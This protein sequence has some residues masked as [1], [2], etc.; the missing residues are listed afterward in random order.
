M[1]QTLASEEVGMTFRKGD[2]CSTSQLDFQNKTFVQDV[3]EST[4]L[5]DYPCFTSLPRDDE[6]PLEFRLDKT[7]AFVDLNNCFL[8]MTLQLTDDKGAGVPSTTLIAPINNIAYSMFDSIDVYIND[9]KLNEN[10]THYTWTSYLYTLLYT[11]QTEKNTILRGSGW[12]ID[13]PGQFDTIAGKDAEDKNDGFVQRMDL[14]SDG[15][16]VKTCARV[17]VTLKFDRLLPPQTEITLKFNRAPTNL[18]LIASEG[19]FRL[20]VLEAKL[21]ASRVK[22]K[23]SHFSTYTSL[24]KNPGFDY[25]AVQLGIRSKTISKGDQNFDWTPFSGPLP[26]RIYFFQLSQD[27]FNGALNLNPLNFKSFGLDKLQVFKNGLSLPGHDGF[28]N[29]VDSN[30]LESYISTLCAVRSF[31]TTSTSLTDYTYG[32]LIFCIDISDDGNASCIYDNPTH[33]GTLRIT[34][35]YKNGLSEAITIFCLAETSR[36]FAIDDDK[37]VLFFDK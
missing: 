3:I 37:N 2:A 36:N 22:L 16:K 21:S 4:Q 26:Q 18:C 7:D 28:T 30:Y 29:M 13:T 33:S 32:N 11:S 23:D 20:K 24:L 8:R 10:H 19:S 6:T 9:R 1:G 35:S 14:F 27:A 31:E 17:F 25:P 15:K 34:G 5:V 12:Y